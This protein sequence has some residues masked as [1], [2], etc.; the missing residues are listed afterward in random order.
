MGEVTDDERGARPKCRQQCKVWIARPLAGVPANHAECQPRFHHSAALSRASER[1]KSTHFLPFLDFD[2]SIH[3][4]RRLLS[5]LLLAVFSL[6]LVSPLFALSMS[7]VTRLPACCRRDGKHHCMGM[8]DQSNLIQ[9]GTQLS[10]P[11]EKCPYC[12]SALAA[13]HTDLLSL[14]TSDAV[15]AS[16]VGHPT[17]VAQTES[18]RRI[19]RDRSRQKRG[20]PS[21]LG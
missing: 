8:A 15:F 18:M 2:D 21:L 7:E 16:L 10:A 5:I 9:R 6:P 12:P 1:R 20:P 17:G 19:S 14:P 4:L 3:L 11:A 13:T